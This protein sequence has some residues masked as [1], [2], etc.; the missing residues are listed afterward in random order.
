MQDVLVVERTYPH[1]DMAERAQHAAELMARTLSGE[2]RPTMAWCSLPI[3][4]SAKKM[5]EGEHTHTHTLSLS[6]HERK[7]DVLPRQAQDKRNPNNSK[8]RVSFRFAQCKNPSAPSSRGLRSSGRCE[9][10]HLL[11]HFYAKR[12]SVFTKTGLGQT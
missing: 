3:L 4:W 8:K 7:S 2:V 5:L 6:C 11:R 10:T 1:V 9:K 12:L